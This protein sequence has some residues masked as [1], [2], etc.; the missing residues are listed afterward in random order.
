MAN[1][2]LPALRSDAESAFH[3]ILVRF[4]Y[5]VDGAYRQDFNITNDTCNYTTSSGKTYN[6]RD[7]TAQIGSTEDKATIRDFETISHCMKE[8]GKRVVSATSTVAFAP[9]PRVEAPLVKKVPNRYAHVSSS[10][11]GNGGSYTRK[12]NAAAKRAAPAKRAVREPCPEAQL[13]RTIAKLQGQLREALVKANHY[14]LEFTDAQLKHGQ[15]AVQNS[16]LIRELTEA[17]RIIAKHQVAFEALKPMVQELKA[18]NVEKDG[19]LKELTSE[20]DNLEALVLKMASKIKSLEKLLIEKV[21]IQEVL[22]SGVESDGDELFAE[23]GKAKDEEIADLRGALKEAHLELGTLNIQ[24]DSMQIRHKEELAKVEATRAKF[25]ACA[26]EMS[27]QLSSTAAKCDELGSK[28]CQLQTN[29]EELRDDISKPKR[30]F[31]ETKPEEAER[32]A[33]AEA[34]I[35][36]DERIQKRVIEANVSQY[37]NPQEMEEIYRSE[38]EVDLLAAS[39]SYVTKKVGQFVVSKLFGL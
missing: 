20:K 1:M 37:A 6:I 13:H 36:A 12:I 14:S 7:I 34:K 32:I 24:L 29:N 25:E 38:E 39:V 26:H 16:E 35:K 9:A 17:K 23:E 30:R 28:V 2:G 11:Y 19:R 31:I 33:L 27:M 5:E 8:L 22:F 4:E 10:G 21:D 15:F 3:D 18:I